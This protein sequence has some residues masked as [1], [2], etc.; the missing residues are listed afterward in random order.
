MSYVQVVHLFA[1]VLH[2]ERLSVWAL[3]HP[4]E[5]RSRDDPQTAELLRKSCHHCVP[6]ISS[7]QNT[8]MKYLHKKHLLYQ[9]NFQIMKY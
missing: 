7:M 8:A 1:S 6:E 5:V 2:S 4:S 9:Y 3:T